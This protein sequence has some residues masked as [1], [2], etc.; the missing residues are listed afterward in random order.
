M[1]KRSVCVIIFFVLSLVF[2]GFIGITARMVRNNEVVYEQTR[3]ASEQPVVEDVSRRTGIEFKDMASLREYVY[4]GELLQKGMS[5]REAEE[6]LAGIGE[7][8][9]Y[10]N[11][12][13][14][15]VYFTEDV[16]DYN[17]SRLVLY[18]NKERLTEW[19]STADTTPLLVYRGSCE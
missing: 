5:R 15:V 8:R 7:M 6:A 1:K 13:D 19:H 18:F 16:L 12:S 17:L 14:E 4:C 3:E 10:L 2:V 11:G 9:A